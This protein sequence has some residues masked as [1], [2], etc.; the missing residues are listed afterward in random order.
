ML[1]ERLSDSGLLVFIVLVSAIF[2]L[3]VC[4]L[5]VVFARFLNKEKKLADNFREV[6]RED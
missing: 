2:F 5:F 6:H 3:V 1:P 4:F